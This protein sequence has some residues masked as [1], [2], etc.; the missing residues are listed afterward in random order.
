M[1]ISTSLL[2]IF[3]NVEDLPPEVVEELPPD[4]VQKLRDGVI[5][6]IPEDVVNSLS[7]SAKDT[8]IDQFPEFVPD[9]VIE[10]VASNPML[11]V[12]LALAGLLAVA[13][14][15]WGITRAAMKAVVIFGLV[16][17]VA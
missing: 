2:A 8:L 1:D 3:Q 16:A 7:E 12:V 11:A 14:F 17:V 13:G 5:D 15:F 4:I 6:T 10:A 9:G